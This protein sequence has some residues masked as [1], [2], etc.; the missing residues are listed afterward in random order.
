MNFLSDIFTKILNEYGDVY[1]YSWENKKFTN[2]LFTFF[3]NTAQNAVYEIVH[4]YNPKLLIKSSTGQGKPTITPWIAILDPRITT[5]ASAGTYVVYL[6]NKD[7]KCVY[8]ALEK[9]YTEV[10]NEVK[11]KNNGRSSKDMIDD[12]MDKDRKSVLEK[13]DIG[14][15]ESDNLINTGKVD[16]DVTA[17]VHKKYSVKNMPEDS[18]LKSDLQEILSIYEQYY[19]NCGKD[20]AENENKE[21]EIDLLN[22][23]AITKSEVLISIFDREVKSILEHVSKFVSARGYVFSEEMIR[24]F[25]LSLKA[26]PFAILAG[27]S[28]TGKSKFTKL[29]AE[30]IG[31]NYLMV[32]VRPDWSDSTD[33][34][35]HLNLDGNFVSGPIIDFLREANDNLE[36]PYILCLDEMNLARVEYYFS[37]FLSIIETRESNMDSIITEN[38]LNVSVF[39]ND[40]NAK[41]RYQKL[42]LSENIYIVG[43][44]NMDE[45]T[46]S[47]SKKVLDRANT[48]EFSDVNLELGIDLIEDQSV[49]P[50]NINNDVMKSEYL[51]FGQCYND[52]K[53]AAIAVISMLKDVNETLKKINAQVAYR[54]RDEVAYYVIYCQKYELM[55]IN[56]ALDIA[57]LQKVLPRIQGS[58]FAVKEVLNDLFK[59]TC[60]PNKNLIDI[61]EDEIGKQ[62]FKVIVNHGDRV[63]FSKSAQK[64]AFMMRRFEDDGYTAYWL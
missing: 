58:S 12:A 26:K 31:A 25:Y 3:N 22:E 62:M 16:F 36:V 32:S 33:L 27:I 55:E 53:Q 18:I 7:E 5:K 10:K 28:G 56:Q 38:I 30:S 64:I 49:L 20:E 60:G 40:G 37:D 4:G 6:F 63:V 51:S 24:N 48:I 15:F 34:F 8:L 59:I 29:F 50:I 14:M 1:K 54:V 41:E 2:D 47:F 9:S 46:Y 19:I 13:I 35:G 44:V 43:T 21:G 11:F 42:Y 39:G 52:N 17:Y 23:K 57:L 61:N 45:T